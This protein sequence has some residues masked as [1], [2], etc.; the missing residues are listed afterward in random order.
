MLIDD[1]I[2]NERFVGKFVEEFRKFDL[3]H[4]GFILKDKI[5]PILNSVGVFPQLDDL[6]DIVNTF[7]EER[8]D[9]DTL[10]YAT[11]R[12][13]RSAD[14]IDD[15][16]NHFIAKA[17]DGSIPTALFRDSLMAL[18][19]R[20]D[21]VPNEEPI[22]KRLSLKA[23]C[24]KLNAFYGRDYT[25][26]EK[27]F[28]PTHETRPRVNSIASPQVFFKGITSSGSELELKPFT[29]ELTDNSPKARRQSTQIQ[30]T[31]RPRSLT[32]FQGRH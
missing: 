15:V 12:Y 13:T 30:R 22:E 8:I 17:S 25:V 16:V 5:E 32:Q 14:P 6:R 1:N 18:D 19:T 21:K 27:E 26:E 31:T 4:S 29:M 28:K 2:L 7:N 20:G 23:V 3:R 11:Y 24:D 9:C 10:L